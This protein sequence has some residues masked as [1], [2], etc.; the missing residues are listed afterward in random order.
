MTDDEH[1]AGHSTPP[2]DRVMKPDVAT[3]AVFRPLFLVGHPRSGTTMLTAAL[4]RHSSI[5]ATPETHYLNRHAMSVE[6]LIPKGT[7]AVCAYF[8]ESRLADLE[9]DLDALRT[10]LDAYQELTASDVF[11]AALNLYAEVR[12]KDTVLEKT[13]VHIRHIDEIFRHYPDARV[14]WLIRDGRACISSL[15]KVDWASD[16]LTV[17]SRQWV[18]NVAYAL[19]AEK[20]YGK[21]IIRVHYEELVT[22]PHRALVAVHEGIGI[23]FQDAELDT[24]LGTNVVPQ[25][26]RSWKGNVG[27]TITS[28]RVDAWRAELSTQE[29][30]TIEVVIGRYLRALG[31]D[32]DY[33]RP[34]GAMW[35]QARGNDVINAIM[36]NSVSLAAMKHVYYRLLRLRI[37]RGKTI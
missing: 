1:G 6:A 18:R 32:Q 19:A 33:R 5:A 17:L 9:L 21:K 3:N 34:T 22:H 29:I 15:R 12:G 27:N 31:Y 16:D 26:E 8:D 14:I 24:S 25:Y 7:A 2:T 23:A 20:R 36:C 10:R 4:G 11:V 30:G 35:L 13:P 37:K 28:N